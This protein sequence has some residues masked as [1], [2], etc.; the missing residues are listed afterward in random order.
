M[1]KFYP[2]VEPFCLFSDEHCYSIVI[3]RDSVAY[4]VRD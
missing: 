3:L 4:G 2:N 1:M